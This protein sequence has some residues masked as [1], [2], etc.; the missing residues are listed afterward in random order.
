MK[1]LKIFIFNYFFLSLTFLVEIKTKH[2]YNINLFFN[3]KI[4][5]RKFLDLANLA[6]TQVFLIYELIKIVI[7]SKDKN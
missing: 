2:Q 7:V 1:S 6:K 4:I 5:L 3:S